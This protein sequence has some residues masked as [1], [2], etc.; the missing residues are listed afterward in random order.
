MPRV[1]ESINPVDNPVKLLWND[2]KAQDSQPERRED[3]KHRV[4]LRREFSNSGP[5]A[6]S[7]VKRLLRRVGKGDEVAQEPQLPV[8]EHARVTNVARSTF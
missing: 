4:D 7:L 6:E 5:S 2:M 8:F 1:L 3:S